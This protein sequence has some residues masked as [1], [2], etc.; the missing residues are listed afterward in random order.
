MA[1]YVLVHGGAHGGW[2]YQRVA[3]LLRSAGHEVYTPTL[4]GVGERSHLPGPGI[5]LDFHVSDILQVLHYE[6]LSDVIL[7]GDSYGGMVVTGVADRATDRLGALVYLDAAH[8]KNGQSLV[9]FAGPSILATRPFGRVVDG[10]ELVLLPEMKH[11]YG[12]ENPADQAWMAERLTGH[13]WKCFEQP[14]RLTNEAAMRA[15]PEYHIVCSSTIGERVAREP[16]VMR[17]ARA[18]GRLWEIDTGHDLMITEPQAVADA[19]LQV[20]A[21]AQSG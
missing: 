15:I 1:T 19:L 17:K 3:R 5:D 18:E 16:D 10:I 21:P 7:V 9:D 2:C 4:T 14:L 6:D 8:P 11:Y 13:P 12:V 20:P